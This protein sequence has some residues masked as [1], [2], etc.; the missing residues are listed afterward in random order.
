MQLPRPAS[1]ERAGGRSGAWAV[2]ADGADRWLAG[3]AGQ[4]K[5]GQQQFAAGGWAGW[6]GWWREQGRRQSDT[7]C[8][9][10]AAQCAAGQAAGGLR[11][12][13][14]PPRNQPLATV[15]RGLGG[16][17][18]ARDPWLDW[19]CC[20]DGC[21][22][23]PI[24]PCAGC[25]RGYP[26]ILATRSSPAT[27]PSS[28]PVSTPVAYALRRLVLP[29]AAEAHARR[30]GTCALAVC[31]CV[32]ARALVLNVNRRGQLARAAGQGRNTRRR[33]KRKMACGQLLLPVPMV[34]RSDCEARRESMAALTTARCCNWHMHVV[35][36]GLQPRAK[37][38]IRLFEDRGRRRRAV[39]P[40]IQDRYLSESGLA[41]A[42][43]IANQL[44]KAIDRY[45]HDQTYI[46]AGT[47]CSCS[48]R[49]AA[50]LTGAGGLP[51]AILMSD[52][53][54]M[55]PAASTLYPAHAL[56]DILIMA[57]LPERP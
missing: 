18:C 30:M 26:A 28:S 42:I 25:V 45:R 55:A 15:G 44:A 20:V 22:A 51:M 54:A 3:P 57:L 23:H 43:A 53:G 56:S 13:G 12:T 29:A 16:G 5:V 17:S 33:P 52:T 1:G 11:N 46:D 31:V 39:Y 27:T 8:V 40:S 21:D 9:D 19:G 6:L 14:P 36:H 24:H 49:T 32:G 37:L 34:A 2:C 4:A 38:T 35:A 47:S 10:D 41:V 7:A 48:W 50:C